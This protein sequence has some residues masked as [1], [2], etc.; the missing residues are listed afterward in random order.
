MSIAGRESIFCGQEIYI[1]G[2]IGFGKKR[3]RRSMRYFHSVAYLMSIFG[4]NTNDYSSGMHCTYGLFCIKS[5]G[6][7]SRQ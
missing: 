3:N 4:V 1:D 6:N 7:P 5:V 2:I